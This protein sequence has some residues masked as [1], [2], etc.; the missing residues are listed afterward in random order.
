MMR[1]ELIVRR[2]LGNQL[3]YNGIYLLVLNK[4]LGVDNTQ[5]LNSLKVIK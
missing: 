3:I 5:A 2:L 4:C 1:K